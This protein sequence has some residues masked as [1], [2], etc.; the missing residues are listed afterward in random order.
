MGFS[1][2]P[3]SYPPSLSIK[4]PRTIFSNNQFVNALFFIDL[5]I[6][7]FLVIAFLMICLFSHRFSSSV[8]LS[9]DS[10]TVFFHFE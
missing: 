7:G 3:L 8:F 6:I 9:E 10:L 2:L 4:N 1:N 5:L